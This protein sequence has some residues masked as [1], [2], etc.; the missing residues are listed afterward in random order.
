[1]MYGVNVSCSICIA[2]SSAVTCSL[3]GHKH[4]DIM[5]LTDMPSADISNICMNVVLKVGWDL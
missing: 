5:H 3:D 2:M 1:M 4:I